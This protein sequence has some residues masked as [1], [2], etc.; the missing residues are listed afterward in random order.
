MSEN[1]TSPTQEP[2][3]LDKWLWCVRVFKTRQQATDA[4]KLKRVLQAGNEVKPSR[5][6]QI[7][8]IYEVQL[9]DITK[10]IRVT[11]HLH[12]RVAGKLVEHYC[13]DLTPP[14]VYAA[15]RERRVALSLAPVVAPEFK[16]DKRARDLIK[17]LYDGPPEEA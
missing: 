13:E 6:V 2:V 5:I 9:P 8:D 14:E 1:Q 17:R 4:C 10:T 11:A 12:Q 3:R 16:P 15:A 7:G